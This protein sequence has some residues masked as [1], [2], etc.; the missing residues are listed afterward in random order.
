MATYRRSPV[1]GATYFFT[2]CAYRRTHDLTAPPIRA[3]LRKAFQQVRQNQPF[4][5]DAIVLLPDHLHCLWTLPADDADF[6]SRWSCIKRLTSQ[7]TAAEIPASP[8]LRKRRELGLWQRRF[9]EHQ[10]RDEDDFARHVDYVHWN[11]VKHGHV[12]QVTA[13]PYSSFHRY[14]RAGVLTDD[15]ATGEIGGEFGEGMQ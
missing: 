6:K 2:V 14:V 12:E 4:A 11:P 7:M 5:V 3:A 15:W 13:W 1:A 10:I 9:W 8:S